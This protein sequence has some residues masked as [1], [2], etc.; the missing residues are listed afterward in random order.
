MGMGWHVKETVMESVLQGDAVGKAQLT[1]GGVRGLAGST[2]DLGLPLQLLT[3]IH[4]TGCSESL[5][6]PL[7]NTEL[8]LE[9]TRNIV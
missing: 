8:L 9:Y 7:A 6:I 5:F 2:W 4:S 1:R 3:S